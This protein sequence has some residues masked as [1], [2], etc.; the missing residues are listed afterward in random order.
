MSP[1]DEAEAVTILRRI[2]MR[3]DHMF[4]QFDEIDCSFTKIERHMAEMRVSL[5][6]CR[7]ELHRPYD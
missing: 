5:A 1:E 3:L 6:R 7:N 4:G 2:D